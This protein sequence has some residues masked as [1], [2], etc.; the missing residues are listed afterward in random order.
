MATPYH[1]FLGPIASANSNVIVNIDTDTTDKPV[2]VVNLVKMYKT[3]ATVM[4]S[5]RKMIETIRSKPLNEVVQTLS[6]IYWVH[7]ALS[8]GLHYHGVKDSSITKIISLC[9]L[10]IKHVEDLD[11]DVNSIMQNASSKGDTYI[12]EKYFNTLSYLIELSVSWCLDKKLP[13]LSELKEQHKTPTQE[14]VYESVS[15]YCG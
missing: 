11:L 15:Y 7:K 2:F 9:D 5:N 13:I 14:D 3:W 6:D 10:I 12:T 4:R 8:H 1:I